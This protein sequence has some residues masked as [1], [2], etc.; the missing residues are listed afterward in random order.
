MNRLAILLAACFPI[1]ALACP[2]P[3]GPGPATDAQLSSY[4]GI[5]EG[6]VV[7]VH[8]VGHEARRSAEVAGREWRGP[9]PR[10]I[11]PE[12]TA[13]VVVTRTL[14]GSATGIV[15]VRGGGCHATEPQ[16]YDRGIFLVATSGAVLAAYS[17]DSSGLGHFPSWQALIDAKFG[18]A[19]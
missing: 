11:T 7:A 17:G 16:L 18:P 15:E 5:F 13:R 3:V 14:R 4:A 2:A 9:D 19:L 10:E 1:A 6:E 8:L 12:F